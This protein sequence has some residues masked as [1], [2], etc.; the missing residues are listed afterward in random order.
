MSERFAHS[1]GR[2]FAE[3]RAGDPSPL[4]T[5]YA[6]GD[7]MAQ[8]GQSPTSLAHHLSWLQQ[9]L[10]DPDFRRFTLIQARA[11]R[12]E[13]QRLVEE[14]VREGALKQDVNPARARARDRGHGR[15]LADV[16]GGASGRQGHDVDACTIWMRCSAR[17]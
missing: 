12:R 13:L 11:S 5:L 8:M 4:A 3:L 2:M 15:R 1:A 17:W 14:A 6:Y 16:V 9:D 10:T 7:C